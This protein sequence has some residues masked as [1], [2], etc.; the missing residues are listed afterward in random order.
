M[1]FRG[2]KKGNDV[3]VDLKV[4]KEND[5]FFGLLMFLFGIAWL[6]VYYVVPVLI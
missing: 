6:F 3:D 1:T 4:D 5:R 2:H